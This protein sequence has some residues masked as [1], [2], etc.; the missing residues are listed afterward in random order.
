MVAA[1]EQHR[2][3]PLKGQAHAFGERRGRIQQPKEVA[4]GGMVPPEAAAGL[5]EPLERRICA[6]IPDLDH[7]V[8]PD[9]ATILEQRHRTQRVQHTTVDI[10]H[11][12]DLHRLSTFRKEPF[13]HDPAPVER[14]NDAVSTT[15]PEP[16]THIPALHRHLD[17]R[18]GSRIAPA[19]R[20]VN[21]NRAS[22]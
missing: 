5:V 15:G 4:L 17:D 9:P 12:S 3:D 2:R 16:V 8:E 7:G 19:R 21:V 20:A 22:R 10:A 13:G 18:V 6:Q 14:R 1:D 11:E